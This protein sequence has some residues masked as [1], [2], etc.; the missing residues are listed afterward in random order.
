MTDAIVAVPL[1]ETVNGIPMTTST[2][3]ARVF[4]KMH[5]H[6]LRDTERLIEQ[7]PDFGRTNFGLCFQNNGLQNGKPLKFYQMTETGF[8]LLAMGFTGPKALQFKLQFIAA[9]N[10]M[11]EAIQS[12]KVDTL[13][14]V[15]AKLATLERERA[16]ASY[17]GKALSEWGHKKDA[18]TLAFEGAKS[19]CQLSLP[20]D[21]IGK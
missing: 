6:V 20:I 21:L 1:I 13:Q 12:T 11:R 14:D 10:A 19:R 15:I 17:A 5:K 7:A 18:L 2:N 16:K 4:G 3:V 8:M 9:F